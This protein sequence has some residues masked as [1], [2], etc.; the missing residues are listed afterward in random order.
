MGNAAAA[1]AADC[2][3]FR[4][5][6]SLGDVRLGVP[7]PEDLL[8]KALASRRWGEANHEGCASALRF[9]AQMAS[10]FAD[11]VMDATGSAQTVIIRT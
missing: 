8:T 2:R 4:R 5:P 6:K 9:P 11:A 10:E 3:K 1:T 7:D